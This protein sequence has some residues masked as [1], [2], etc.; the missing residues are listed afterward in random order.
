[1]VFPCFLKNWGTAALQCCISFCCAKMWISHTDVHVSPP[2]RTSPAPPTPLGHHRALS[3]VPCAMQ[4]VPTS[5][6]SH[7]AAHM[8]QYQSLSSSSSL[9]HPS[10]HKS[11]LCICVS[12]PALQIRSS[13][14]VF[15]APHICVNILCF[16]WLHFQKSSL[17]SCWCLLSL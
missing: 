3:W 12:L 4:Q 11:I 16:H 7:I 13:V 15:Y 1:M 17:C 8:C 14:P 2:P 5:Y 9:S 6:V 10:V